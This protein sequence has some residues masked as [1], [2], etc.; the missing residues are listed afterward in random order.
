MVV[1]VIGLRWHYPTDAVAGA[2]LG[3]GAVLL[4]DGVA[5]LP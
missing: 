3:V 2:V 4:V 5:H 1:A